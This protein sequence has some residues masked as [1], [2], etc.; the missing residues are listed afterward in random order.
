MLHP[1]RATRVLVTL[2]LALAL[3]VLLLGGA[4]AATAAVQHTTTL[5]DLPSA[6]QALVS[7]TLGQDDARY[8]LAPRSGGYAGAN[9]AQQIAAQFDSQG[10]QFTVQGHAVRMILASWSAGADRQAAT[11]AMPQVTANRVAW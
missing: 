10:A 7:R 2:G 5:A 4:P 1:R 11:A 6:A 9:P 3:A 8:Q